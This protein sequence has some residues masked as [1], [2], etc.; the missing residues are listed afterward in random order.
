MLAPS[1]FNY[2]FGRIGQPQTTP[3]P[4]AAYWQCVKSNGG[5]VSVPGTLT[6]YNRLTGE[7]KMFSDFCIASSTPGMA[8]STLLSEQYCNG[9]NAAST[10]VQCPYGCVGGACRQPRYQCSS[11]N[12]STLVIVEVSA[13]T[14]ETDTQ[15]GQQR[16]FIDHCVNASGASAATSTL[17][18]KGQCVSSPDG[19]RLY[20][21]TY[22]C[23]SGETCS[24]GVCHR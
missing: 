24:N 18:S 11:T 10:T 17:V 23:W 2:R 14:T 3:T 7:T 22:G 13:T 16:V 8:T 21:S 6:L 5:N 1:S 12:T 19:S 20:A 4:V 15:T 9:S